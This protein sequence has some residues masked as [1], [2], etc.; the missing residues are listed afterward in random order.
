MVTTLTYGWFESPHALYSPVAFSDFCLFSL[1]VDP[2]HKIERGFL[3]F[4]TMANNYTTSFAIVAK[5]RKKIVKLILDGKKREDIYKVIQNEFP[6]TKETTIHNE[7]A[8]AKKDIADIGDSH[9]E[10]IIG[11]HMFRYEMIYAES[12]EQG[13]NGTA[14]KALQQKEKLAGITTDEDQL[15]INI[16][17]QSGEGTAINGYDINKLDDY[18]KSLFSSC[19]E[20]EKFPINDY[21]KIEIELTRDIYK[22]S[23]YEFYKDAFAQL[24]PGQDY[25]ENWH[26]KYL[27]DKLQAEFERVK[28]HKKVRDKDLI[29]NMPFRA[30]KSLICSV[31]FPIW[32]W[33]QD[34]STKFICV[35]YAEGIALKLARQSKSLINSIWFQKY[36]GDEVI[37]KRDQ[38]GVLDM[39]IVG[40]GSRAAFGMDGAI[41]GTGADFIIID[42]PQ[43]PKKASSEVERQTTLDRYDETIY[44]RLNQPNIGIRI[45]VMQRLHECLHPDSLIM[46]PTG[47]SRIE[48]LNIGDKVLSSN[49]IDEVLYHQQSPYKGK[50]Y[51]IYTYGNTRPIICSET[52][53][54]FTEDGWVEARNLKKGVKVNPDI[55]NMLDEDLSKIKFPQVPYK[56]INKLT[57]NAS[58]KTWRP[59]VSKEGIEKLIDKGLSL[60]DI[61]SEFSIHR[62]TL[63]NHLWY[64][65]IPFYKGNVV[66]ESILQKPMFWRFVGYWLAEG[67][68]TPLKKNGHTITLVFHKKEDQY[69][70]EIKNLI[71]L[72]GCKCK[73]SKHKTHNCQRISFNSYQI[74]KFLVENFKKLSKNKTLPEW[75]YNLPIGFIKELITGYWRGDGCLSG[76]NVRFSSVSKNLIFSLRSVLFQLGVDSKIY[77]SEAEGVQ[78]IM[79]NVVSKNNGY[80]LKAH[81]CD[82]SWLGIKKEKQP[83]YRKDYTVKRIEVEDYQDSL[84]DITTKSGNFLMSEM[85]TVHNCDLSG[86]LLEGDPERKRHNHICIPATIDSEKDRASLSPPELI[87]NYKENLFWHTRFSFSVLEDYYVR[88][89]SLQAA[90]QLQQRPAPAEGLILKRN[91]FDIV[92]PASIVRDPAKDPTVF[93]LD[94]AYTEKQEND[95]TGILCC[96]KH[97]ETIYIVNISETWQEFPELCKY[98]PEY[99]TLNGYSNKSRIWVEPKASG[100]SLVQQLRKTTA[101]NVIEI[102]GDYLKDD[103]KTRLSA[104]APLIEARKVKLIRGAWNEKYLTQVTTFPNASHDEFVDC[105]VYAIN[106]LLNVN[107]FFWGFM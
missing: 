75:V 44:S 47:V 81:S 72:Y 63:Y 59:K 98:V 18:Q 77:L 35:S 89:G 71:E 102:E 55:P 64:Y 58:Y 82:M 6:N 25:D 95:P 24:H 97:D 84:Y 100:K 51:K 73:I 66:D 92:D 31:I 76:D 104:V 10:D 39:G 11:Q 38:S 50:L 60:N 30:S 7:I 29:I 42:D 94:T 40:E 46:T 91:W 17:S 5:R 33:T 103:K 23:Y 53:K 52:H 67:T 32:C 99:T 80:E 57:G 86:Y 69:V 54:I 107:D 74:G 14:M 15:M 65:K 56:K 62:N 45:I 2:S 9:V 43:N 20:S 26:A 34:T 37:L 61:A 4:L 1:F 8:F 41:T 90:G 22:D 96:F 19:L 28:V 93:I 13:W 16:S 78:K 79:G 48:D 12:R 3:L 27:C 85:V 49:G 68:V 83:V 101:L 70:N 105:T 106:L 36:Y 21:E 88:L 87:D